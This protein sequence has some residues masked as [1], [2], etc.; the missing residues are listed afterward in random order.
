[1]FG[2]GSF[3]SKT[4]KSEQLRVVMELVETKKT[5]NSFTKAVRYFDIDWN[6]LE[7]DTSV[8]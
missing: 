2:K 8:R 5:V 6:M 7:E 3:S 4:V 1:M